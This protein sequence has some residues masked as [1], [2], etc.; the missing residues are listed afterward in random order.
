MEGSSVKMTLMKHK[1]NPTSRFLFNLMVSVLL[2]TIFWGVYIFYFGEMRFKTNLPTGHWIS[3]IYLVMGTYVGTFI[4]W[5]VWIPFVLGIFFC[6]KIYARFSA[7]VFIFAL[8]IN[9]I[10][11]YLS[12][13]VIEFVFERYFFMEIPSGVASPAIFNIYVPILALSGSVVSCV[14]LKTKQ[15]VEKLTW[16]R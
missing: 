9:A 11:F 7:I 3:N 4:Q 12:S 14:F 15:I 8:I 16:Q 2:F 1:T 13:I 5:G 6:I 10:S